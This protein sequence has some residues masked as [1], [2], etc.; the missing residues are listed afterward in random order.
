MV[1][2]PVVLPHSVGPPE[3]QITVPASHHSLLE[4]LNR[5]GD[6]AI[7]SASTVDPS[8]FPGQA[9]LWSIHQPSLAGSTRGLHIFFQ[10]LGLNR[11]T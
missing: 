3:T 7:Q 4:E 1:C 2:A 5:D 6:Q 8:S 10:R 9:D 11:G